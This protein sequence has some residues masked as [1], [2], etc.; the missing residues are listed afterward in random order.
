MA[1]EIRITDQK[2]FAK[3]NNGDTFSLNP[4]DFSRHLKGGVL[5]EIK[6]VFNVQ[7][8][9]FSGLLSYD[10]L[11]DDLANTLRI[12]KTGLDFKKDGFSVGDSVKFSISS[13]QGNIEGDVTSLKV[14]EITL[15]NVVIISGT[16]ANGWSTKVSEVT[17][18][19]LTGLTDLTA[20]KYKF[21][22]IENDESV[23]FLSK[24]T[25]TEQIFVIDNIDHG[26]PLTFSTGVSQSNNKAWVTGSAKCAFVGLV[27]DSDF[28]R[29]EDTTQEFQIEHIFKINPVYRDG[30]IDSLKGIDTPPDDI[31][32]GD[33]SLKYVFQTEFRTVLNN[34]NTSKIKDYDTQ[35]GSVGYLGE[36]YNGYPSDYTIEDLVYFNV[37]DAVTIDKIDIDVQNRITF[38]IKSA[39]GNIDAGMALIVG[40]TAVIDSLTYSNNTGDYKSI[41]LDETLRTTEGVGAVSDDIIQDYTA[42]RIDANT[43]S[44]QYDIVFS[45]GKEREVNDGQDYLLY[46]TIADPTKTVDEGSKVTDRIDV[47]V[48]D[49]SSDISG[50]FD[51]T[52]N[53]QYP[54]PVEFDKGV[55]TGFTSGKMF[56]EDEQMIY[57]R[58][59]VLN[60]YLGEDLDLTE[61]VSL[62]S[63]SFKIVAYNTVTNTWFNLRT[64]NIDLTDQVLVG[65]IQNIELDSTRGYI[66]TDTDIFNSLTLTT[67]NNDGTFQFYDLQVGYK[68]P[69]QSWL[70]SIDADTVFY[71]KTKSHN[72]LNQNSSNYSFTNNY[73]IKFLIDANVET[74]GIVTNY[75]NRSGDFIAYNYNTD[76]QEPDAFTCVINTFKKDG[77]PLLN[78]VIEKGFTELRGVFTPLVPPIFSQ[79]VDFT[80][81]AS[82]WNRFAHGNLYNPVHAFWR[83]GVW[84]N[85]QANDTDEFTDGTLTFTKNSSLYNSTS[86]QITATQNG[87]AN[88]GLFSL[89]KFEFYSIEGK[90][91]S[92]NATDDDAILY[93]IAFLTDELGVEHTLSVG[94]TTGGAL[95]DLEPTF[96]LGDD[97]TSTLGNG[98]GK[99]SWALIY[100][101]GKSGCRQLLEFDT[102]ETGFDWGDAQVQDLNFDIKRSAN[103]ITIDIEWT[104]NATSYVNVF[105]FD[106]N[107]DVDTVKFIGV[108]FIGFS[109]FSQDQGGFKDVVLSMPT[110]DFYAVLRMETDES[111]SD[112][113]MNEIN[114]EVENTVDSLLKQI[115]GIENK[116]KLSFDGTDFI[117][118]ALINTDKIVDG[119]KYKFS[120]E[121]RRKSLIL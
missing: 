55:S 41:W 6:A 107:S 68:I 104:I 101:Y 95:L 66:L 15:D 52:V 34:P 46:Y 115:S 72:G 28:V 4:S 82:T 16:L 69:W 9:W 111:S 26:V 14:G 91:F 12:R 102:G 83:H 112:F 37:T 59:K 13:P 63:L 96:V 118:Q 117:V 19:I 94:A 98:N 57:T 103:D 119:E 30:E 106:L 90:M 67:D 114:T 80:L 81:V 105:N 87:T 21:G 24:L 49:K 71:D 77:V 116:A 27:P 51:V 62:E 74:T 50:L 113:G 40:H 93:N 36:S 60:T 25:N 22:L 110:S 43:L 61:D 56:V 32:D 2:F 85:E 73:V 48:Y 99:A 45:G 64:L 86:S 100:D 42:T 35:K 39:N 33:L 109:F 89:D 18:D 8:E 11:Y 79:S 70:E 75:V 53:E 3:L 65:N 78:N 58:F 76:D 31:F 23:N 88:Y 1:S 92:T 20:L 108:Q 97:S 120:A 17:Q 121:L 10:M 44:V 38:N 5:E 84:A 29:S 7:V 54:I 47:N